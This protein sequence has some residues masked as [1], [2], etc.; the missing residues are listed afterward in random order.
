MVLEMGTIETQSNLIE[1]NLCEQK[2]HEFYQQ[3][4]GKIIFDSFL[5]VRFFFATN[6]VQ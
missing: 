2:K 5:F 4:K 6:V 1:L 3:F